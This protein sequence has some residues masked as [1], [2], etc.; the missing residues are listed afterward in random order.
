[1]GVHTCWLRKLSVGT[2]P[3][4]QLLFETSGRSPHGSKVYLQVSIENELKGLGTA[5]DKAKK[6]LLKV[7]PLHEEWKQKEEETNKG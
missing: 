1:M 2:Q 5:V 7:E 3:S 4:N 6:E